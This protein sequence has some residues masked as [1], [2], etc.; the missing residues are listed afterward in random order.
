MG[1]RYKP[2]FH[3]SI[4]LSPLFM[5]LK[6]TA[7]LFCATFLLC[8]TSLQSIAQKSTP[9]ADS[10]FKGLDTA[11]QRVLRNW[12][13]AGFA[14][15]VVQKN[16]VVY[17]RGF[18]YRDFAGK[19]PVTPNTIF[20]IGSCTKS[21]TTAL[22]GKLQ[23][24]GKLD[25]D[26]PVNNYLPELKFYNDIMTANINLR[27]MM[28]H[29]TGLPRYDLSWYFFNTLSIDSMVQR[30]RYMEPSAGLRE[31]WQYNN[32]M[33]AAQGAVIE[34]LS[35]KSWGDNI[36]E[37]LFMP[38]EM[39]HSSVSIPELEKSGDVSVGYTIRNDNSIKEVAYYHIGGM[40]PAGA[41]N[42]NVIDM[43]KW[44]MAWINNGKYNGKEVIPADFL[45]EAIS[46]QSIL[47]G[48]LP[49]KDHPGNYFSNYGFGW[50]VDSYAGHYRVEHGGNID[51]FS[52]N[53]SFFPSDSV[54]IVV[55][56]NQSVSKV[57]G[58]V[59]NLISDRILNLPYHDWNTE[60]RNAED[61][62]DRGREQT[63]EDITK[64]AK[65]HPPTHGLT[66]FAGNYNHPAYGTMHCF[67][68]NDSL[69]ANTVTR[70]LWLR[71]GNYDVFEVFENDPVEGIDTAKNFG[72]NLQ[73]RMNVSGDIDGFE[74][75]LEGGI[76]PS[77][78]IKETESQPVK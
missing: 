77:I 45:N 36:K 9:E 64:A 62:A 37:S 56:S 59:R 5:N 4:I 18:G 44:V 12:H 63:Q 68:K 33:Y 41:I 40:A 28:S 20:P 23:K 21:F 57:P 32:F 34:K 8:T 60:A 48:S 19:K 54:G 46:S 52:A 7:F 49:G 47:D 78:W 50:F 3:I 11:F 24:D 14:V 69:F 42:S 65:H 17:A 2:Y 75:Q 1:I 55:L 61:K 10:R 66:D 25:I 76:K 35:G 16:K 72:I 51:G 58:L 22:I 43:A 15:V 53:T 71:H 70:T 39:I 30:I 74:S 38:L 27:D 29:R 31:K 13:A 6:I 67:V 73:F 26:K